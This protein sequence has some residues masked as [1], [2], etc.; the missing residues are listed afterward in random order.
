MTPKFTLQV[1]IQL[2]D[3]VEGAGPIQLLSSWETTG[4]QILFPPRNMFSI[5]ISRKPVFSLSKYIHVY[6]YIYVYIYMH[7]DNFI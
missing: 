5:N 1:H 7:F 2:K 3:Y 6:I 4:A